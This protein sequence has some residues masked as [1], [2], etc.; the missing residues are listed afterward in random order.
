[1]DPKDSHRIRRA[2]SALDRP[3]TRH[4]HSG[5]AAQAERLATLPAMPT[6]TGFTTTP[7]KSM[8]LTRPDHIELSKLGC[9]G[10]RRFLCVR[11]DGRR[12]SGISKATLMPIRPTYDAFAERLTLTFPDG[13]R[14]DGIANDAGERLTVEL[15]DR[16]ISVRVLNGPFADAIRTHARDDT[17]V[18][19]RVVEPGYGGGPHPVSVISRASVA[20]VGRHAGDEHLDPRR[21]RM[22]IEI[23]GV[24]HYEEDAWQGRLVR[25]GGATVRIGARMNRCVMTTLDPD[26]GEQNAPV[27]DALAEHRKVGTEL[28][29]G[30]YGDVDAPGTIAVGDDATVL[31]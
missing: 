7:V 3:A 2:G 4:G 12:L 25:F 26:T 22:L 8:A 11:S 30:V 16:A 18:F 27:L 23:D 28:L 5:G 15:F 31:A 20:D 19:A 1:M 10:D 21:F 24:D 17:L 6:V 13:S 14:V 9:L 29:L